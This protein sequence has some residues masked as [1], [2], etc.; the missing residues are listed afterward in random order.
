MVFLSIGSTKSVKFELQDK[1]SQIFTRRTIP[2]FFPLAFIFFIFQNYKVLLSPFKLSNLVIAKI[3]L[4]NLVQFQLNNLIVSM[5]KLFFI[6]I[7]LIPKKCIFPIRLSELGSS[8]E[9]WVS[10]HAVIQGFAGGRFISEHEDELKRFF[11]SRHIQ[12]WGAVANQCNVPRIEC[13]DVRSR[14]ELLKVSQDDRVKDGSI[15]FQ[16]IHDALV[17]NGSYVVSGNKHIKTLPYDVGSV[18]SFPQRDLMYI[19]DQTFQQQGLITENQK[20][21]LFIGNSNNWYHFVMEVL[22]RGI[23]WHRQTEHDLGVVFNRD[24]PKSIYQIIG[25]IG[26]RE[27]IL[28]ADG[29]TLKFESLTVA[30]DGRH[31]HQADMHRIKPNS[32]IFADRLPDINLIQSWMKEK[33]DSGEVASPK[34]VFLI[35]GTGKSRPL[36]NVMQLQSALESR[37]FVTVNPGSL[38]IE[39]QIHLFENAEVMVAEGGAALT[40]LIFASKMK[41]LIHIE[42]NPHPQVAGFWQQ[43]AE[44]LNIEAS[45]CLGEPDK[46]HRNFSDSYT[47]SVD[48][49]IKQLD[50][51]F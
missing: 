24:V 51:F 16:R 31:P 7:L 26:R 42:A 34:R 35:R 48:N 40:N 19:R 20:S 39:N 12:L 47:I 33:F 45:S 22:P 8:S 27:P 5:T 43:F 10:R 21:G 2:I 13:L 36:K 3:T 50:G 49:L 17:V 18:S 23:L 14:I 6:H 38:S 44:V 25:K 15:L 46:S 28:I 30:I 4:I 11:F 37:G 29:E 9:V 32:N 41:R 1:S